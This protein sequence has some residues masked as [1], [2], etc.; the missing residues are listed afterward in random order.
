MIFLQ[1]TSKALSPYAQAQANRNE[2]SE[3]FIKP[4]LVVQFGVW[5]SLR[6]SRAAA[7]VVRTTS[8]MSW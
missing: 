4:S 7:G 3:N 1:A 2:D 8:V 6:S 5:E